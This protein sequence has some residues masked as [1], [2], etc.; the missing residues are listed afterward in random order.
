MDDKLPEDFDVIILGTGLPECMIAAACAR[1]GLSVLQLDRNDYYGDLWSSFN[2]RTIQNW[3]TRDNRNDNEAEINSESFLRDGE[4]FLPV[5]YRSFVKNVHQHFFHDN[6]ANV[7][8]LDA[9]GIASHLQDIN[10]QWRKFSLDLLPKVLLS[11]GDMVKLL[12][13]SG[14]AK[15]CE[16]KC[17]DRLLSHI[18]NKGSNRL[19]VV[20]CSRGE[21]FRSDAISLKKD[22]GF[23]FRVQDKR[24]VMRF[25]QKCIEWRR[26]PN[27]NDSWKEYAEKPFDTFVESIGIVGQAKSILTDTLAILHPSSNTKEI[28]L[29]AIWQFMESVGR[30]G[31]SPFLWTLYGSGEL[32]QCFARLCAVFGGIYCLN[33]SVDGFIVANGRIVAVI[34]QGQR[35]KCN[36]VI[37][38]E[39]YVPQQYISTSLR[40]Q[41][42][43]VILITDRSILPD[44][45]KEHISVLNL[46]NLESNIFAYL[47]EAGYEGCVAPKGRYVTHITARSDSAASIILNPIIDVFFNMTANEEMK[48]RI[49][50]S[51][52]F[53][54]VLPSIVSHTLPINMRIVPSI[55]EHLNYAQIIC[56][57]RKIFEELW[58]D[59]DFLPPSL[60]EEESEESDVNLA[61]IERKQEVIENVV[62]RNDINSDL[63]S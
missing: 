52:Y 27:E 58:P 18:S 60:I 1:S 8:G 12:C 45:E 14:V 28:S 50:W 20:P 29:E 9:A 34:T 19:E 54:L 30:F 57:V 42:N 25:L 39:A 2:L 16:F 62:E 21:I 23:M 51:L 37:A 44:L 22:I 40:T 53:D 43:R 11:R 41:L 24:R 61:N 32:P 5:T 48:P 6:I 38:N 4:E 7:E 49:L 55:D 63:A 31:D 15:Y 59:R 3:I 10:P 26:N 35:I 46:S 36:H 56:E 33:R 17:V 47:L 13:D